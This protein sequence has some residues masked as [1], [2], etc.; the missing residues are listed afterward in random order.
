MNSFFL[1]FIGITALEIFL[2]IKIGGEIGAL[3]TI[4]LIFLTA[5]IGLYFV[6]IQGIQ[7]LKSGMTNLYQNKLP[8]YEIASGASLAVSALLLILPGFF[9]DILGFLLLIPFTRKLLFKAIIKKNN[10]TSANKDK[11]ILDGEIVED[12]KDEL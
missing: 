1:F 11:K 6:K 9:T 3:S 12:K 8:V 10:S 2:F 4:G 7:T 5:I